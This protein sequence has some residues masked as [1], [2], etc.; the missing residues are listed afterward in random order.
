MTSSFS[1]DVVSIQGEEGSNSAA[2][3][4]AILGKDV[5]LLFC[6]T[7]QDA[8]DALDRDVAQKSVLPI[9]NTTA[10]MI[11]IVW[12]YITGA[13]GAGQ[14]V[15]ITAEAQV[16]I[17]FVA[18]MLPG[19]AAH[20]EKI[21]CHPVAAAQCGRFLKRVGWKVLP[22]DD[23]A[24]AARL[25]AEGKDP[26]IAALCPPDAARFYGLELFESSCGDAAETLTRFALVERGSAEEHQRSAEID[27]MF[28]WLELENEPGSLINGLRL[29]SDEGLNLYSI[30]S[31]ALAGRPGKY[32]FIIEAEAPKVPDALRLTILRLRE[33]GQIPVRAL[34]SVKT[35]PWRTA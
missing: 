34:G 5:R 22:C 11:Q 27:R 23:T 15:M 31:R 6:A 17:R 33:V 19:A 10:G 9:E 2:A 1:P 26:R 14:P 7:F 16:H 18:G 8:F 35:P 25:V 28:L 21:L 30:Q 29:F 32:A 13:T 20:V 12:D 4:R 3:A 24:G